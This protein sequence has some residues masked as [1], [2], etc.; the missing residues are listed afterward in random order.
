MA[1]FEGKVS[2]VFFTASD[3]TPAKRRNDKGTIIELRINVRHIEQSHVE[4]AGGVS[5][6]PHL[7]Q[8]RAEG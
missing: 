2:A 1:L 3:F 5:R 6:H 8:N 7:A 4:S